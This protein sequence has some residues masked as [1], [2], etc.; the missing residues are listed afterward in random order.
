MQKEPVIIKL[1]LLKGSDEP[2]QDLACDH[3]DYLIVVFNFFLILYLDVNK[4]VQ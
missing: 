3:L 1:L 4:F 2:V